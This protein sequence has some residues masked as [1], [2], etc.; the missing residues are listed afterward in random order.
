MKI[1]RYSVGPLQ[2]NCYHLI[3]ELTGESVIIDPGGVTNSLMSA[4]HRHPVK[5]IILTHGHFD[6]I[7]G[8]GSIIA[9]TGAT[10]MIHRGDLPMLTNPYLNCSA[11]FAGDII[12]DIEPQPLTPAEPVLFGGCSL[13]VLETPGHSPGGISLVGDGVV[14][15]GDTLFRLAVGR[16]D[17]PG[18]DFNTLMASIRKQLLPL[19]G[20]TVVYPGHGEPTTIAYEEHHNDFI[21]G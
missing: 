16:W 2:T 3:C 21:S 13:R 7:A 14:L 15:A 20:E 17:L 5:S 12:F 4:I 18:D 10:V 8:L 1:E 6:H 19:P 11:T 9:E